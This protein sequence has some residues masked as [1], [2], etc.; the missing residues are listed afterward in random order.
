MSRLSKVYQSLFVFTVDVW[1]PAVVAYF[2]HKPPEIGKVT[3]IFLMIFSCGLFCPHTTQTPLQQSQ[4]KWGKLTVIP[5]SY[6]RD[7]FV[8]S[9]DLWGKIWT[10]KGK[11][12]VIPHY[13]LQPENHIWLLPRLSLSC[14]SFTTT[15][16]QNLNPLTLLQKLRCS[17]LKDS[18]KQS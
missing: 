7:H 4:V 18:R 11:M 12:L 13:Q 16:T 1:N 6:R 14:L 10:S 5:I 17:L 15:P 8:F 9:S 2:G 3:V